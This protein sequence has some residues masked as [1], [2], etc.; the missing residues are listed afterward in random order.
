MIKLI[1]K[2]ASCFTSVKAVAVR[3]MAV[4]IR[5]GTTIGIFSRLNLTSSG[6]EMNSLEI[7]LFEVQN[8]KQR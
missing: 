8:M 3:D 7:K 4:V 2:P 1:Y 5:N 6:K